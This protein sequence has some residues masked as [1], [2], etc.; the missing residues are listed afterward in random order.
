MTNEQ[1]AQ[2]IRAGSEE[3]LP[4]LWENVER[5]FLLKASSW[6][7]QHTELCARTGVAEDDI[8]QEAYFAFLDTVKYYDASSGYQFLTFATFPMKNRFNQLCGLRT[9]AQQLLPLNRCVS[10]SAPIQIEDDL[11]LEDMILD[12]AAEKSYQDAEENIYIEQLHNVLESCLNEIPSL[13][14]QAVKARFYDG[15]SLNEVGER[16]GRTAP[17]ARDIIGNGLRS[18]RRG[19]SIARL[20]PW[21]EDIISSCALRSSFQFWKN[22]G[23]SSTEYAVLKKEKFEEKALEHAVLKKEIFEEEESLVMEKIK[24]LEKQRLEKKKKRALLLKK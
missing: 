6:Y 8:R 23:M 17:A 11:T 16:I 2:S 5:F 3:L 15:M 13:Q 7:W 4:A 19:S 10:L 22:S 9:R 20:K 12:P 24:Y 14:A 1:L 21:Q 18:L